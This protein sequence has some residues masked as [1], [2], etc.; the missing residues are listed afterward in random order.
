MNRGETDMS[1]PQQRPQTATSPTGSGSPER[2]ISPAVLDAG[3]PRHAAGGP[4][5]AD[6][7]QFG[8]ELQRARRQRNAARERHVLQLMAA[9]AAAR[10]A[11]LQAPGGA[12]VWAERRTA[13]FLAGG[14]AS[15]RPTLRRFAGL[16][17][18]AVCPAILGLI[19]LEVRLR[20]LTQ[21][22]E[23]LAVYRKRMAWMRLLGWRWKDAF[24]WQ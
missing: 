6:G 3:L 20:G 8:I 15:K 5:V 19:R 21:C 17:A 9:Q 23:V 4:G 7:E 22:E 11:L 12:C 1:L 24:N 10:M 13:E 2:P 18:R 16:A 14:L